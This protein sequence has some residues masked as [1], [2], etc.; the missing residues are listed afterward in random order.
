MMVWKMIRRLQRFLEAEKLSLILAATALLISVPALWSRWGPMD[1]LRHRAKLLDPNRLPARLFETGLVPPDSGRLRTVLNDLHTITRSKAQLHK[2]RDYGV[3]P[4]WTHPDYRASNWRP[5]DSSIHWLDYR[6][7]PDCAACIHAHSLLWFAGVIAIMAIVYRKF[8][9]I[10]WIAGL[11]AVM[12]LLDDSNYVP[13]MWIA[14]R[15]LLISLLLAW[16]AL[17]F[18]HR[19]RTTANPRSAILSAL[20]LL[21]ALLASESA[22]AICAYLFA[23]AITLDSDRWCTRA[24]SLIPAFGVVVIWRIVYNMFGNGG[25]GSGFVIDPG[26]EPLS[27]LQALLERGPILLFA[28]LGGPPSETVSFAR[29]SLYGPFWAAAVIFLLLVFAAFWPMLKTHRRCRFWMIGMLLATVP[30]CATLPMNRNLLYVAA[31]AFALVAEFI[32]AVLQNQSWLGPGRLRRA[33]MYVLC[34]YLLLCHVLFAIVGR[35]TTPLTVSLVR[36]QFVK[37]MQLGPLEAVDNQS[38]VLVNAPN[39]FGLFFVP[40]FRAHHRQPLP[41]SI[42]LLV[43]AFRPLLVHRTDR[44]TLVIRAKVGNLMDCREK[45]DFDFVYLFRKFNEGFRHRRFGFAPGQKVQLPNLTVE[46]LQIDQHKQPVEVAFRFNVPLEDPSLRWLRWDW[47]RDCYL[48][49]EPPAPGQTVE[50]AGPF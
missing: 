12:Y 28:Q 22:I 8:I 50:L 17:L 27:F 34:G 9:E 32:A 36:K 29:P 23:Y 20:L 11:A 7:W 30:I 43:P 45:H 31:G 39:P 33:G 46:I 5:V 2:L 19:W 47:D 40:T 42:R 15:Q 44:T 3:M 37:T 14:N 41:K 49:F 10:G 21:A 18:H 16:P 6:L 24:A 4:W 26:R 1:D 38:L 48:P 35:I 13:A 25:Y